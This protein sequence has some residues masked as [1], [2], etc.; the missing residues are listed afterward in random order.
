MTTVNNNLDTD[1]LL[2]REELVNQGYPFGKVNDFIPFG[3]PQNE[4]MR[5]EPTVKV[6]IPE[7]DGA[8]NCD[9]CVLAVTATPDGKELIA[10]WTQSS[11]EG[12]GNNRIVLSR[13]NDGENWTY[14]QPIVGT[15]TVGEAQSSWGMP[16]FSKSGRLYMMYLQCAEPD[17]QDPGM[18]GCLNGD[19]ALMYSDDLGHS[20]SAPRIL[21]LP[22]CDFDNPNENIAKNWWNQQQPIRDAKGRLV[23]GFTMKRSPSL[24]ELVNYPHEV[25]KIA[26]LCF[27]N[28]DEDPEIEDIRF[29]IEPENGLCVKDPLFPENSVAQEASPVLLPDGRMFS[30]MRTITGYIY[31]T[32]YE[33]G[34]WRETAPMIGHDGNPVPHPL[35]PCPMFS[36]EDGRYLCVFY[37]NPGKR[38]GYDSN[39]Y[40]MMAQGMNVTRGPLHLMLGRFDPESKQ[41]IRFG[42]PLKFIDTDCVA[43]GMYKQCCTAPSYVALTQWKGKTTLWYP[44]RKYNILGKEITPE[45]LQMLEDGLD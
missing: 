15:Y 44:D 34:T 16:M 6:F 11:V 38:L 17:R 19:L 43:L 35:G 36:L 31:Y 7:K 45:I 33:N 29:V 8:D 2:S 25:T 28:L 32:V 26:F 9:N 42:K 14:P 13:T 37:N 20:W 24:G 1:R 5:S 27:E 30:T 39:G 21:P 4:W 41:P 18:P 40:P 23:C 3:N 12:R 22:R 10:V